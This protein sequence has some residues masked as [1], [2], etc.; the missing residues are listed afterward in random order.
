MDLADLPAS[1]YNVP[2]AVLIMPWVLGRFFYFLLLTRKLFELIC[3]YPIML[4]H[5]QALQYLTTRI[6]CDITGNCTEI[7]LFTSIN[8]V[9]DLLKGYKL[10]R[11]LTNVAWLN[12]E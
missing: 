3:R 9:K 12:S 11:H 10:F 4:M 2:G 8:K 7:K 5:L 1:E 6:L